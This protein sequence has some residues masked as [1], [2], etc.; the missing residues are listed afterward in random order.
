M[1]QRETCCDGLDVGAFLLTPIQRV[2]RYVLLL[3][4]GILF[5]LETSTFCRCEID[6][7]IQFIFSVGISVVHVA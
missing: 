4:V 5:V 2:P 6:K 7:I 1:S 3:K